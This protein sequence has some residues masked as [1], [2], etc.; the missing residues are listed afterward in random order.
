MRRKENERHEKEK[1]MKRRRMA[2]GNKGEEY[3]AKRTNRH[4]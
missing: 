1:H 3:E 2:E 4:E